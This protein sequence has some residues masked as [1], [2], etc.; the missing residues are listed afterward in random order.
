M[1]DATRCYTI[2]AV[3]ATIQFSF[4]DAPSLSATGIR[5]GTDTPLFLLQVQHRQRSSHLS[6]VHSPKLFVAMNKERSPN[7]AIHQFSLTM[8]LPTVNERITYIPRSQLIFEY[9]SKSPHPQCKPSLPS[10]S[11]SALC[12]AQYALP[13]PPKMDC[14][15]LPSST[16]YAQNP[17]KEHWSI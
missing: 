6:S 4:C 8:T 14:A 11:P 15:K 1:L 9:K 3:E 13:N 7:G 12:L 2:S 16:M 5:T 10:S 17:L